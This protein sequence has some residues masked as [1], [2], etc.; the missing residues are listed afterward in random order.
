MIGTV[1]PCAMSATSSS[2]AISRHREL[3]KQRF[4][5]LTEERIKASRYRAPQGRAAVRQRLRKKLA[6]SF[7]GRRRASPDQDLPTAI[8]AGDT[9]GGL[10][11]LRILALSE[12]PLR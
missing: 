4:D 3:P 5:P 2:T 9:A 6:G 10:A 1:K 7:A 11:H 12:F 8:R